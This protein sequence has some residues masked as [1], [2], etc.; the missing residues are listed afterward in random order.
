MKIKKGV[1]LEGV[2]QEM[3]DIWNIVEAEFLKYGAPYTMITSGTEGR[4]MNGSKHYKG[5][6][7]DFRTFHVP[8]SGHDGEGYIRQI[9][10]NLDKKLK[11]YDIVIHKKSHMHIEYDP[12]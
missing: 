4:H 3:F 10:I 11:G 12:K 7:L 5:L 2:K 8:K 6:A 1:I 9:K